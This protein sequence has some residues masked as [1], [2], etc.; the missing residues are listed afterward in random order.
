[1]DTTRKR[2]TKQKQQEGRATWADMLQWVELL[3]QV[4]KATNLSRQEFE[5]KMYELQL[6]LDDLKVKIPRSVHISLREECKRD[7]NLCQT[8]LDDVKSNPS[9][10]FHTNI[11]T[12]QPTITCID[13]KAAPRKKGK[14]RRYKTSAQRSADQQAE[15][16][17]KIL[18]SQVIPNKFKIGLSK[19]NHEKLKGICH[20]MLRQKGLL[21]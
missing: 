17:A 10:P 9:Q 5:Q 7:V 2:V 18:A 19:G 6:K 14:R 11:D 3:G 8:F 16:F 20:A 21:Q 13:P 1:M 15:A 12:K 4:D